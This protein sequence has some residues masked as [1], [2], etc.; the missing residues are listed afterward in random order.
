MEFVSDAE[1]VNRRGRLGSGESGGELSLE[2]DVQGAPL[3]GRVNPGDG[4]SAEEEPSPSAESVREFARKTR[5]EETTQTLSG[6][7]L[8]ARG[9]AAAL[10]HFLEH[11]N[12]YVW[13]V[14][15]IREARTVLDQQAKIPDPDATKPQDWADEEAGEK[16]LR[17]L[18]GGL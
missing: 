12:V 1:R 2:K 16:A 9:Y 6:A 4:V 5:D 14:G 11:Y 15:S 7:G 10:L 3:T 13:R 17:R 8:P 18:D